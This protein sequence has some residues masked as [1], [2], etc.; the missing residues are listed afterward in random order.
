[1]ATIFT[2]KEL[3]T[4]DKLEHYP[5]PPEFIDQFSN[6]VLPKIIKRYKLQDSSWT[7]IGC[8]NGIWGKKLHSSSLVSGPI[9]GVEINEDFRP[10][11]EGDPGYNDLFFEDAVDYLARVNGGGVIFG[12][13]PYF[14][15]WRKFNRML[16]LSMQ[17]Y[18]TIIWLVS[19]GFTNTV[20]R[21]KL[22]QEYGFP[23]QQWG[24]VPRLQW[25]NYK[26]SS[27]R[28]HCIMVWSKDKRVHQNGII[29][30]KTGEV[31]T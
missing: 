17:K 19:F 5:T 12:N 2:T 24:I 9:I 15:D 13:P 4:R 28:D 8:G 18:H 22:F 7:D 21:M 20:A 30:W 26:D 27:P 1:M 14:K 31:V 11:L 23:Q 3:P 16:E 10:E 25:V 6:L 29:N